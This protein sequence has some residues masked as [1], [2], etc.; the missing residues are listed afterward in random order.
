LG[1]SNSCPANSLIYTI[2]L[3]KDYNV[4][5]AGGFN[6]NN[7]NAYVLKWNKST[8]QW[9]LPIRLPPSS[10]IGNFITKIKTD[11]SGNLYVVGIF[12]NSHNNNYVAVLNNVTNQWSELGGD[13]SLKPNTNINSMCIDSFGNVYVA[14]TFTNKSGNSYVAIWDKTTNQWSELG[15]DNSLKANGGIYRINLDKYGNLY[16]IGWFKNNS[17][18]L[19]VA[20]WNKASN[21]WIEL[22]GKNSLPYTIAYNP[23]FSDTNGNL[24]VYIWDTLNYAYIAKWNKSNNLWTKLTY[25][26]T[27]LY[28][29]NSY[30][31]DMIVDENDNIFL[32]GYIRD[33]YG[34]VPILKYTPNK[35]NTINL[36]GCSPFLYKGKYYTNS[37]IV[38]DTVLNYKG[39]DS[40][41]STVNIVVGN[42][43]I[44]GNIIHPKTKSGINFLNP[45]NV[46]LTGKNSQSLLSE[47]G[48]SF[49]C[50]SDSTKGIIRLSKNNDINKANGVTAVDIALTQA[51]ILGKN[52]LN[53]PYKLIA[54]DVNG[55]AK[56][57]A[58]DIVYMK[59]LILGIDT[60][61]TNSVSK[62]TRLWAFVDSSYKFPDSTNPFPFKDS[63]SYS[64]LS[65]SKT[66]QTF[67]GCKLGDVNW[68]W[69]PAVAR[70][71]VDNTNAIELSYPSVRPGRASDGYIHIPVMVKNFKDMLG[72]QF[73]IRFDPTVLQW[74]GLGNNPL[75]IETGTNHAGEG[76]ISFLW[77]DPKNEIKTLDDGSVLFNLVFEKSGDCIN[78]QLS[79]DGSITSVVAYDKDY[80][81]HNVVFKP[82]VINSM[83]TK[84]IWTIAPNPTKDGVIKVQM[85]LRDNKTV[86]FRLSDIT[87]RLLLMKQVEGIKG[88]NNITLKEGNI[89]SGTYYLQAVGVEGVKQLRIE[90]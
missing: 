3:D 79:L 43:G 70:P 40:I 69:N 45:V 7:Q 73:T 26:D 68:D 5:I 55:D 33:N 46:N 52:M 38:Y 32:A 12:L 74:Q 30:N 41:F 57:T 78:E 15:G 36:N 20:Q 71:V 76:S 25:A 35:E 23:I 90:N 24:Y 19:Y 39:C 34:D 85:N 82:S 16:G 51:N 58:L 61:F 2:C 18:N 13:N 10:L 17:G 4:Y 44:S 64:G 86:V 54:A 42:N 72:M 22:G 27:N 66:N 53:S 9:S 63:I 21:Q 28:K 75:G 8:N 49:N 47:Q 65:A 56:V 29:L 48:Y 37:T 83:E 6:D 88:I 60:T 62:Q 87:G 50:L 11:N 89:A 1:G 31:N 67:I 81:S 84:D 80:Q 59:R 77:V 14:G